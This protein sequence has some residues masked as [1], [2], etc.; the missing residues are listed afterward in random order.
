M[1]YYSTSSPSV[2]LQAGAQAKVIVF[3]FMTAD[4]LDRFRSSEGWS[5]GANAWVAVLKVGA[6]G[7]VHMGTRQPV[8][9]THSC[10]RMAA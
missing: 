1:R 5:A 6:N 9:S 4:A 10:S 7:N 3:L 2:G 8:R